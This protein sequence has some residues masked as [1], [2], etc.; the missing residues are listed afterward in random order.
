LA[1]RWGGLFFLFGLQIR[2]RHAL[3]GEAR[4]R[5]TSSGRGESKQAAVIAMLQRR[6][7]VTI[8]AI[9]KETGW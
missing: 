4:C 6:Q 7:G 9:M 8:A 1:A 3:R 2:E 5:P